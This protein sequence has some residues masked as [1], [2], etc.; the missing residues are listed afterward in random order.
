MAKE[1]YIIK[2]ILIYMKGILRKVNMK[3]KENIYIKMESIILE[4]FQMVWGMVKGRNIFSIILL[5][6]MEILLIINMKE[7]EKKYMVKANII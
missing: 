6:M 1:K 5:N 7:M 3:E 2:I 4:I